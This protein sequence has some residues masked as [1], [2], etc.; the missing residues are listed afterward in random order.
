[1]MWQQV[2]DFPNYEVS[3]EGKV[4]RAS[5]LRSV[6]IV[7]NRQGYAYVCLYRNKKRKNLRLHRLVA[8]VFCPEYSD[9]CVVH[10]KDTDRTNNCVENLDPLSSADHDEAHKDY[11]E[12][13]VICAKTFQLLFTCYSYA[14]AVDRTGV[15]EQ[16]IRCSLES[17][18]V[19]KERP[20]Y[21]FSE[22]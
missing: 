3:D 13:N 16:A 21:F 14:E 1:M 11:E 18:T 9:D 8:K 4:R 6:A 20:E 22:F 2:P 19:C 5:T 15:P 7:L 10:H 17:G 12:I